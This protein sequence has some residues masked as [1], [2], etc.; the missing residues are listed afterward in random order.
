MGHWSQGLSGQLQDVFDHMLCLRPRPWASK[1]SLLA[2]GWRGL[3]SWKVFSLS[4][5]CFLVSFVSFRVLRFRS[6]ADTVQGLF[7]GDIEGL[8]EPLGF[9]VL[10]ADEDGGTKREKNNETRNEKRKRNETRNENNE[11][12]L[13][14]LH[15]V[16]EKLSYT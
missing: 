13:L 15:L 9:E 5:R 10:S 16:K 11:L 2:D 4:S 3:F 6:F 7:G 8:Q 14:S 1:R 12:I